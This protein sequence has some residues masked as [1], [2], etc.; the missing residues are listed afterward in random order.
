MIG[1][2]ER[3]E[4]DES[5]KKLSYE[6]REELK[7]NICNKYK[8]HVV[9]RFINYVEGG[10]IFYT[11]TP[12]SL[13]HEMLK[14]K[15]TRF[16][17][18]SPQFLL[19]YFLF[20]VNKDVIESKDPSE[21]YTDEELLTFYNHIGIA[22]KSFLYQQ[23]DNDK[24]Q[25]RQTE[26]KIKLLDL[27]DNDPVSKEYIDAITY[28]ISEY[29]DKYLGIE[30]F[31]DI[32]KHLNLFFSSQ[33]LLYF[34]KT[35]YRDHL[36]HMI[37]IC[38]L[39]FFLLSSKL[40]EKNILDN[41]SEKSESDDKKL[42]KNWFIAALFHDIGYILSLYENI[43]LEVKF[44]KSSE[45]DNL[46][47]RFADCH[48]REVSIFNGDISEKFRKYDIDAMEISNLSEIDHGVI[49]ASHT[50]NL[51]TDQ[52]PAGKESDD[53][54][55]EYLPAIYGIAHHNL[56]FSGL[57]IKSQPIGT[58]LTLLDELQEWERQIIENTSMRDNLAVSIRSSKMS[59]VS[60]SKSMIEV[61]YLRVNDNFLP[62]EDT[63]S[64]SDKGNL[65]FVL[66]YSKVKDLKEFKPLYTWL[67]K[68]HKMQRLSLNKLFNV[69][70]TF[71]NS[72]KDNEEELT[73]LKT[74]RRKARNWAFEDWMAFI[75]EN[76]YHFNGKENGNI[77][78][79]YL[80]VNVKELAK[81]K[82]LKLPPV[83]YLKDIYSYEDKDK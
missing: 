22:I 33:T 70:V 9:S 81:I 37:D 14:E 30:K 10:K 65:D 58:L 44:L 66:D 39:G 42:L 3:D 41:L 54:I 36:F 25:P 19:S 26:Q 24:E 83:D 18:L 48:K 73:R 31:F 51:I 8:N 7:K 67:L 79:E 17:Q 46:K 35:N 77:I 53:K 27:E 64:I 78:M 80:K 82:P 5:G 6:V 52:Y 62:F 38:L 60:D 61:I 59:F 69:N 28:I 74:M 55:K 32:E 50:L 75:K 63:Y 43:Q 34:I 15:G 71:V 21:I 23:R 20:R 12:K 56:S 45:I 57:S 1:Y 72:V 2:Y 49:S 4:R 47:K 11:E 76:D 29:T 68:S 40:N 13:D 16:L